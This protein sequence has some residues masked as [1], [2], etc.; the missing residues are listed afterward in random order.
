MP[1]PSTTP[2]LVSLDLFLSVVE[3]G[4]LSKAAAAHGMAQPSASSRIRQLER[5]LG[6]TLLER[7]P[8][9]SSPT[10]AGKLVAGWASGTL[11]SAHELNAGVAALKARRAGELR[12]A[13]SLTIAEY[14]LPVW[15]ESFLRN[16]PDD[17]IKLDVLNSQSVLDRL[18][19]RDVDLG[20]VESPVDTP[21][22]DDQVVGEDQLVVVV[23]P[24]HP[25]AQQRSISIDDV[26]HASMILREAGSGTRE[27]FEAALASRGVAP[28]A[29][30]LELG[31]TS[32]VLAAVTAGH[33]PTVLSERAVASDLRAG[34]LIAVRVRGLVV[35]RQLRALWTRDRPLHPLATELLAGLPGARR[36]GMPSPTP[37]SSREGSD[38]RRDHSSRE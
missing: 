28:P 25:W 17:S 2:D 9:G 12:I 38:P 4:S 5:R 23:P 3:L 22:L 11:R 32:A 27:S 21:D 31:S 20:F 19:T 36:A 37:P 16:R 33:L 15:L 34:T 24:R 30:A 18:R 1:L 8:T 10:T 6:L 26:A 7:S 35:E 13:A 29:S 14:L